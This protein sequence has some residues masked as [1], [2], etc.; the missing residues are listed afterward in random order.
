MMGL[1]VSSLA[2]RLSMPSAAEWKRQ[3]GSPSTNLGSRSPHFFSEENVFIRTKVSGASQ[4]FMPQE[5]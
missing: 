4:R 2:L 3:L 5:M 1:Y